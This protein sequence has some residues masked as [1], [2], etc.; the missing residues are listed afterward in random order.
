VRSGSARA[1]V[2]LSTRVDKSNAPETRTTSVFLTDAAY[3]LRPKTRRQEIEQRIRAL[4]LQLWSDPGDKREIE[5][6][7]EAAEAE[8]RALDKGAS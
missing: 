5:G 8:L 1:K 7:I 2:K 4:K 3:D 6:M